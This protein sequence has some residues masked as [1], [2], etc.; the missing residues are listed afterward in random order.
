M[1]VNEETYYSSNWLEFED[2]TSHNLRPG[3]WRRRQMDAL[4][5][6]SQVGSNNYFVEVKILRDALAAYFVHKYP[7]SWQNNYV[8]Y[9]SY[10]PLCENE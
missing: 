1:K 6:H 5:P 9:A 8:K 2:T 7:V 3:L 4:T 10:N